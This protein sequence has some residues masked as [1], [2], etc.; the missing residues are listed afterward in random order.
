MAINRQN[1]EI[2]KKF[3]KIRLSTNPDA[4]ALKALEIGNI[5]YLDGVL[6]TAREGVYIKVLENN[7]PLPL[8]LPLESAANFHCSPAA[9]PISDPHV[10]P[11]L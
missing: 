2:S 6:Y 11:W 8:D 1:G 4:Q 3:K 10:Q 7:A 5:V 9:A